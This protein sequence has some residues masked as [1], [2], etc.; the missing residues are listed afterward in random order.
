MPPA[1]KKSSP[2]QYPSRWVSGIRSRIAIPNCCPIVFCIRSRIAIPN[3]CPIVFCSGP[4]TPSAHFGF[5]FNFMFPQPPAQHACRPIQP[6]GYSPRSPTS[7][8]NRAAG[9]AATAQASDRLPLQEKDPPLRLLLFPS[10]NPR[11]PLRSP[12]QKPMKLRGTHR[13]PFSS[14]APPLLLPSGL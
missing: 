12:P 14:P 10:I 3:C 1:D 4:K 5:L 8:P 13:R 7:R 6:K 9:A 11:D 2:Y